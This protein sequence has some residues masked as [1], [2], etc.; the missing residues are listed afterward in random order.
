MG[1]KNVKERAGCL[2][3]VARQ[4]VEEVNLKLNSTLE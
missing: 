1:L 4:Q 3:R 2:D